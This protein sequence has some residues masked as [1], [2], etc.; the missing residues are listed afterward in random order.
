MDGSQFSADWIDSEGRNG[1]R[2]HN[3]LARAGKAYCGVVMIRS[4]HDSG[5]QGRLTWTSFV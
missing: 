5:A 3:T 1:M 4:N 2:L